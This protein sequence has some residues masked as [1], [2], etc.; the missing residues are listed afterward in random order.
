MEFEWVYA[1]WNAIPGPEFHPRATTGKIGS[2]R[3]VPLERAPAR[4]AATT[5]TR[6]TTVASNAVLPLYA[7]RFAHMTRREKLESMLADSPDDPFLRYA[8]ALALDSEGDTTGAIAKLA[9][10]HIRKDRVR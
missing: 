4:R 7:A 1:G 2:S 9:A 10:G 5:A 3:F 6:V 8:L